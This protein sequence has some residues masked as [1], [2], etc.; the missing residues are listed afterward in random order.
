MDKKSIEF[1]SKDNNN[2]NLILQ[3]LKFKGFKNENNSES[4][5]SIE[6]VEYASDNDNDNDNDNWINDESTKKDINFICSEIKDMFKINI[7][8]NLFSNT[9]FICYFYVIIIIIFFS[10]RINDVIRISFICYFYIIKIII[11]FRSR[12]DFFML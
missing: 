2:K 10:I 1:D 5:D 4:I 8:K 11:I 6:E 3:D 9:Y 12:I 7:K